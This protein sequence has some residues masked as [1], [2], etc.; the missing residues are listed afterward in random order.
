M[1]K[2]FAGLCL[3][4]LTLLTAVCG[5]GQ[6][7]GQGTGAGAG[8]A[9]PRDTDIS[10]E[11]VYED[12]ME[13]LYAENFAVDYYTG[14]FSLVTING[15]ERYLVAPEGSEVPGDLD[16]DIT[17]LHQPLDEIYLVASAVM[18]MFISMDA[19]DTLSF[20]GTK[21]DGWY[22]EEEERLWSPDRFCMPESIPRPTTKGFWRRAA[23][24]PLKTRWFTIR[25][26]SGNSWRSSAFRCWW[27]IPAM[28]RS[29]WG[30]RNG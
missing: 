29:R 8:S 10:A 5:C 1:K 21:A 4:L 3:S 13:L 9:G 20:T 19:L 18:D 27:I 16:E 15:N 17:V 30:E 2:R 25:R 14:G 7:G 11:L 12:S 23:I 6:G 24:W 26:R 28:K 22:L